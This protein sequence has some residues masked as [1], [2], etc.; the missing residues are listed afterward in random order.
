MHHMRAGRVGAVLV[1]KGVVPLLVSVPVT[2]MPA[3]LPYWFQMALFHL[4]VSLAD[5]A[6]RML[7]SSW[8]L[9]Q[10]R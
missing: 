9:A 5:C 1:D 10:S 6:T 8:Y 4:P 2:P 3:G 7:A